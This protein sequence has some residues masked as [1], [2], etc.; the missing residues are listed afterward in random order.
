MSVTLTQ[1]DLQ[2]IK[3]LFIDDFAQLHGGVRRLHREIEELSLDTAAAFVE[4]HGKL[5]D[6]DL[7]VDHVSDELSGVKIT[8][9]QVNNELSDVKFAVERIERVQ[10]AEVERVDVHESSLGK[11]R[12]IFKK[13]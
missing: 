6:M 8:L 5:S 2:A 4:V 3:G 12:K 13:L 10:K 9:S 1:D 11:M 7:K